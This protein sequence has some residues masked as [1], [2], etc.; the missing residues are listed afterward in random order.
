MIPVPNYYF[1]MIIKWKKI[2]KNFEVDFTDLKSILK[3]WKKKI[4]LND[5]PYIALRDL[6]YKFYLC[7]WSTAITLASISAATNNATVRIQIYNVNLFS[8]LFLL[9]NT[10]SIDYLQNI[11]ILNHLSYAVKHTVFGSTDIVVY[12]R[13]SATL[14]GSFGRR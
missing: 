8:V 1:K 5:I 10:I 9:S 11:P 12:C 14:D 6:F 7:K 13:K 4:Y 2:T 3:W